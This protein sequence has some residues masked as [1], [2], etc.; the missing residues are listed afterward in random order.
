MS[1]DPLISVIV[2]IY[3]G[4]D[5][6]EKTLSTLSQ[7]T[8]KDLEFIC[9]DDGSSDSSG[10]IINRFA[11]RDQRFV[12]VHTSNQG[13]FKARE[14]GMKLARGTY[15]GFC[16][17]DDT[18]HPDMYEKMARRALD[19]NSDMTV[20]AFRRISSRGNVLSI[21]MQGFSSDTLPVS[22]QSGWLPTVNTS[23]WNKIISKD[24]LCSRIHLDEPPR[25]MED[26]ML[27]ISLYPSMRSISF[28]EEPLYDYQAPEQSAMSS[29][30]LSEIPDLIQSW[31]L[32]RQH[33]LNVN[34]G[35]AAI[36][37][38]A[39]FI[40]LRVSA[41]TRMASSER[42]HAAREV[43]NALAESFP[44]LKGSPFMS[45]GYVW[46]HRQ[47]LTTYLAYACY[48]LGLLD[49]ALGAY[50]GLTRLTGIEI[51]W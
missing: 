12:P 11:T 16:D 46:L 40:H 43:D 39:A 8:F 48:R 29:V 13:A 21:E 9:V 27:L 36:I 14:T 31:R 33:V 47:L 24:I 41:T 30:R 22:A 3:N 44:L 10:E 2:P 50:E 26:A 23:L 1:S 7:Q 17:A 32:L 20:C 51:K 45:L 28:L 49:V 34:D 15:I 6:L 4:Q 42:R 35:F 38:L 5:Y 25:V 19:D 18:P 37:D